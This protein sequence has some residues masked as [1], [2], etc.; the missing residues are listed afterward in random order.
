MTDKIESLEKLSNLKEKWVI[1]EKEFEI[2]K[3]KILGLENYSKSYF[4]NSKD[5]LLQKLFSAKWRINRWEY[6]IYSFILLILFIIWVLLL[7][8]LYYFMHNTI[9]NIILV[10]IMLFLL[11][12]V[13]YSNFVLIIKK[14]HDIDTNWWI[15]IIIYFALPISMFILL[16]IPWTKWDNKYWPERWKDRV[17]KIFILMFAWSLIFLLFLTIIFFNIISN[18]K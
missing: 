12:A 11:I 5:T 15:S 1:S 4:D 13:I 3:N 6:L 17:W 14:L 9:N 7:W 2:E 10:I 8:I 16:F 18:Y